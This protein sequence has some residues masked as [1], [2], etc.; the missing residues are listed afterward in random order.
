MCYQILY[1]QFM[2]Q[3]VF[4]PE[5]LGINYTIKRINRL[6]KTSETFATA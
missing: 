1:Q 5:K 2:A 6:E 3:I 4:Q